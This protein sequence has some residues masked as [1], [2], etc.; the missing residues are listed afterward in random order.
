MS[1]IGFDTSNYTTS[2]AYFD[3]CDGLNCSKLLWYQCDAALLESKLGSVPPSVIFWEILCRIGIT[4]SLYVQKILLAICCG[5]L[6][7]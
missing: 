6:L 1:V 5:G 3:G 4:P 2:V 7:C